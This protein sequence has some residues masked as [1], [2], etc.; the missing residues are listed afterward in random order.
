MPLDKLDIELRQ[1]KYKF[2]MTILFMTI[3]SVTTF[4]QGE[5]FGKYI[6]TDYPNS[7]IILNADRTFKFRF[8]SHAYWD[9]ACGQFEMKNDTIFFTYTSDMFDLSC[10]SEQINMTDTSDYFL[11]TGVDKTY[12]PLTATI[13]K[14]EI[15]TIKTGDMTDFITVDRRT[16]Y[17]KRERKR[18]ER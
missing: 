6:L 8:R 3:G 7:Y 18:H 16:Y 2:L 14:K 15:R 11:K 1:M 5:L 12:R 9:L 17:Y 13:K 4:G 10:N